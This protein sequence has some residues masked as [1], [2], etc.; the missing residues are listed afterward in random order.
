MKRKI[1]FWQE[2]LSPHMLPLASRLQ[3][4]GCDITYIAQKQMSC[5]RASQGW[6]LSSSIDIE[7]IIA[8]DHSSIKKLICNADPSTLHICQGIRGNGLIGVAQ[9]EL[10][11]YNA[12]QWVVME[13]VKSSGVLGFLREVEYTRIFYQK[14]SWLEGVLATGHKNP[15][16]VRARCKFI[17]NIFEFAYFLKDVKNLNYVN[18]SKKPFNFLF[19]GQLI[20]RKNLK[21]LIQALGD[22]RHDKFKLTVVGD[23]PLKDQ[24][25]KLAD[26]KIPNNVHWLGVQ[27]HDEIQNLIQEADCLVLPSVFDGWGAV[28]SEAIMVG[29]PVICSD[30]CGAAGVVIASKSGSVFKAGDSKSLAYALKKQMRHGRI[31][32]EDRSQLWK[33]GAFLGANSGAEYLLKIFDYV[34]NKGP[35]P[36]PPWRDFSIKF[37]EGN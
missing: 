9:R 24:L 22:I 7:I 25:I 11:K 16:W 6:G 26:E 31:S 28:V 15:D 35:K 29:T 14:S 3:E 17:K 33:W 19:V 10:R 13:E 8:P 30:N 18:S 37:M 2:I 36:Y 4:L 27:M 5:E 20:P 32:L 23:G 34:E 12:R 1:W 21:L